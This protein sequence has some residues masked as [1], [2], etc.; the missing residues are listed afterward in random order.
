MEKAYPLGFMQRGQEGIIRE[1]AGGLKMRQRLTEMGMVK[2]SEIKIIRNDS[3][4]P[5]I[6]SLGEERLAIGRGVSHKILI[7]E[8]K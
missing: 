6:I 2:G 5:L 3:H 8:K 7:E 4:G 1:M